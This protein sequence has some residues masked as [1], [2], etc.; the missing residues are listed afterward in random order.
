L[1]LLTQAPHGLFGGGRVVAWDVSVRQDVVEVTAY[2]DGTTQYMP[3]MRRAHVRL[4][5]RYGRYEAFGLSDMMRGEP[6]R[7]DEVVD[8]RRITGEIVVTS[9]RFVDAIGDITTCVIEGDVVGGAFA[10]AEIDVAATTGAG[11]AAEPEQGIVDA[12]D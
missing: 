8:G 7:V 6:V 10:V 2:G 3:G 1:E 4:A 12:H 9:A 5:V 11:D